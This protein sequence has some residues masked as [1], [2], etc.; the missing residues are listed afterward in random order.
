M[1]PQKTF[2][3]FP[4]NNIPG[5]HYRIAVHFRAQDFQGQWTSHPAPGECPW[6]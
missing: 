1:P 2:L 3:S 4:L 6:Q 5:F